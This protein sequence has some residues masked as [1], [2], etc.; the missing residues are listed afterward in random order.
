MCRHEDSH[1]QTNQDDAG[2]SLSN[3][4]TIHMRVT[5][6]DVFAERRDEPK[7]DEAQSDT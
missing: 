7:G 3:L 4:L 1:W 2:A 5:F 6:E